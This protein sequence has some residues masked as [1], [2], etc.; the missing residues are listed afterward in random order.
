MKSTNT[1]DQRSF[2]IPLKGKVFLSSGPKEAITQAING[3]PGDSISF[4]M[5]D[6][7]TMGQE[8]A[9][10]RVLG[11]ESLM[12]MGTAREATKV[13]IEFKG[14]TQTAWIGSDGET[15][16]ENGFLGIVMEKPAGKK[17]C[18]ALPQKAAKI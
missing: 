3:H 4:V 7:A 16:R 6:P 12:N 14:V 9:T 8:K 18:S 10:L 13:S 15:I 11:K 1:A 5:F 17:H 2:N